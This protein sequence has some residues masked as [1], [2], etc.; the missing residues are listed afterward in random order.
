MSPNRQ[1]RSRIAKPDC[2]D[3]REAE[4]RRP[5]HSASRSRRPLQ[6]C[7]HR[8]GNR[9]DALQQEQESR[10]G[11]QV[12]A[13]RPKRRLPNARTVCGRLPHV[14]GAGG[15]ARRTDGRVPD[16]GRPKHGARSKVRAA[17]RPW[18]APARRSASRWTRDDRVL[19]RLHGLCCRQLSPVGWAFRMAVIGR[20]AS[21]D[22][23][24]TAGPECLAPH[25]SA[26]PPALRPVGH[27]GALIPLP[28]DGRRSCAVSPV[29]SCAVSP[30]QNVGPRRPLASGLRWHPSS[31]D[32]R[33]SPG[34][35]TPDGRFGGVPA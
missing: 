12:I 20:L 19:C 34:S 9:R 29:Q 22:C 8:R 1:P 16:A 7:R 4:R 5:S 30:V 14:P 3:D 10:R 28:L 35:A 2:K 18:S 11:R 27:V 15:M 31:A 23:G 13:P 32:M 26:R 33:L 25:R 24:R 17:R 6:A 21:H